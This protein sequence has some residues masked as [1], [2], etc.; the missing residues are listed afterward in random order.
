MVDRSGA[1][2][3]KVSLGALAASWQNL[4]LQRHRNRVS[5]PSSLALARASGPRSTASTED[6]DEISPEMTSVPNLPEPT[7][8]ASKLRTGFPRLQPRPYRARTGA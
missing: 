4:G 8:I 7:T 3:I 2:Q 1:V 6:P 5:A